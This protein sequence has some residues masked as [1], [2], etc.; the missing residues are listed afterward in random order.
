LIFDRQQALQHYSAAFAAA[1]DDAEVLAAYAAAT[2]D[3]A[4]EL[5]LLQR[6]LRLGVETTPVRQRVQLLERI[7]PRPMNR[8]ETA[9][10]DYTLRLPVAYSRNS[11]P[12]GWLLEVRLNNS[13][14]LRL[15]L[16]T[17][18]RGIL[19]HEG[20][21]RRARLE[22]LAETE[23]AGFGDGAGRRG[24]VWLAESVR[25]GAYKVSRQCFKFVKD[26]GMSLSALSQTGTGSWL[27]P[28]PLPPRR[29]RDS[30]PT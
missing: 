2:P 25:A 19:L 22:W 9:Y 6:L 23:L 7:G 12:V 3:R 4:L 18:A 14:P 1:P 5:A 27:P 24:Q 13:R 26:R 8:L 20:A 21:A 16:D 15:L 17:G 11:Q 29:L 28:R 30:S 10:A